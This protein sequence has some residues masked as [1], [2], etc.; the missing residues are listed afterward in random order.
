MNQKVN[1]P[2]ENHAYSNIQISVIEGANEGF[3]PTGFGK[4]SSAVPGNSAPKSSADIAKMADNV[5]SMSFP[6]KMKI[7]S[8]LVRAAY[9]K[10]LTRPI[11][12]RD[13]TSIYR[14]GAKL[15]ELV[16]NPQHDEPTEEWLEKCDGWERNPGNK[17]LLRVHPNRW[18]AIGKALAFGDRGLQTHRLVNE[19]AEDTETR[20]KAAELL[21]NYPD[22]IAV[23]ICNLNTGGGWYDGIEIPPGY[24]PEQRLYF[25]LHTL[26]TGGMWNLVEKG[27]NRVMVLDERIGVVHDEMIIQTSVKR[28]R[29]A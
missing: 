1:L 26:L 3:V 13:F 21:F 16:N 8:E 14:F 2:G 29:F 24:T 7:P 10:A 28:I 27:E 23:K 20:I 25:I 17:R 6:A 4:P 11:R 9:K 19:H 15:V 12:E 5:I 18:E 22:K